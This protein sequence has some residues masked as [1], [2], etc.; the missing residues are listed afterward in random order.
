MRLLLFSLLAVFLVGIC[1]TRV[2]AQK[3]V[4]LADSVV[5]T[6]TVI[7]S[8]IN[9]DAKDGASIPEPLYVRQG[10][11]IVLEKEWERKVLGYDYYGRP[12]R[13]GP[14]KYTYFISKINL[15]SGRHTERIQLELHKEWDNDSKVRLS[16]IY[17]IGGR[18]LINSRQY[19]KKYG[20][21]VTA[22]PIDNWG[23]QEPI[24]KTLIS[25]DRQLRIY[26]RRSPDR[27]LL[28]SY[29][30]LRK[31]DDTV[32][33]YYTVTDSTLFVL[34]KRAIS[35]G[36]EIE[37]KNVVDSYDTETQE[38]FYRSVKIDNKGNIYI[39]GTKKKQTVLM[40]Y[41]LSG[42]KINEQRVIPN[43][44]YLSRD[45]RA[46]FTANGRMV[47]AGVYSAADS[48]T[49]DQYHENDNS[50]EA[51]EARFKV[52]AQG[53]FASE[54]DA[55]KATRLS[56][57]SHAFSPADYKQLVF[58][59]DLKDNMEEAYD[60]L[61]DSIVWAPSLS[62]LSLVSMV[63]KNGKVLLVTEK[64]MGV[65][66]DYSIEDIIVF[67]QSI[68][69]STDLKISRIPKKQPLLDSY[70]PAHGMFVQKEKDQLK[71]WSN[72]EKYEVDKLE[73]DFEPSGYSPA[74]GRL[75][76]SVY[77]LDGELTRT[78]K[79][80]EGLEEDYAFLPRYFT[81]SDDLLFLVKHQGSTAR[82]GWIKLTSND[83][84]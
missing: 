61:K 38:R 26:N 68:S 62:N 1:P 17:N 58:S 42:E 54:F 6:D 3:E 70:S 18:M 52:R 13:F 50:C 71:V 40:K 60:C 32:E 25:C 36:L 16:S 57:V 28:L 55:E 69:D 56:Y 82:I 22:H 81:L 65:G 37:A 43:E 66:N 33:M 77:S 53:T 24:E 11:L 73:E 78:T 7:W 5:L 64:V 45:F 84:E 51:T 75:T 34:K 35:L 41:T 8:K 4:N 63:V 46:E 20:V 12:Y 30:F 83:E 72:I 23:D 19:S 10:Y 21:K 79:L 47:V 76:E 80:V 9:F 2:I 14:T 39:I 59:E 15:N 44:A 29:Y 67:Q 74:R 49:L 48:T 27:E 31:P